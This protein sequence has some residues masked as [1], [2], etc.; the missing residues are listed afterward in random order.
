MKKG[1]ENPLFELFC[2]YTPSKAFP[3]IAAPPEMK[4]S[5]SSE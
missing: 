2:A 1:A 5:N 4:Q 3:Q